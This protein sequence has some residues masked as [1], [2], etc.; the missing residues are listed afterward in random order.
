MTASM[1]PS[2]TAALEAIAQARGWVLDVDG[3]LVRTEQPGGEGGTPFPGGPELVAHLKARG[4][5]VVCCTNASRH[6]PQTY[7][8]ELRA[9][10][11][12]IADTEFLTAGW[13]AAQHIAAHHPGARVL[14]LGAE[15]LTEPLAAAGVAVFSS[16]ED[17]RL[18]DVVVVGAAPGYRASSID[19]ACRA[20]D[21]GAPLYV[22]AGARWFHGG[23]A[24][25]AS[26]SG[27]I[28]A[29]VSW[30][31]GVAPVV[32]GKPSRV[33]AETLLARLDLPGEQ[34]VVVGDSAE[35]EMELARAAG[36]I[37]VLVLSG[38]TP[39]DAVGGLPP[40]HR[41]RIAVADVQELLTLVSGT[42]GR[43]RGDKTW[44]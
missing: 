20:V 5:S 25:S 30:V 17:E 35:A 31:T 39:A 19:R 40:G 21:A 26:V 6:A 4:D 9:A 43:E 7:A 34:V 3:C 28:A 14:A 10:G 22:T 12:D 15:G 36:A 16:P 27:A 24:P 44:P 32:V 18:A 23:R 29:A 11:F 33:L 42:A 41:P 38:A 1:S 13:A 37:G 2:T 8:A